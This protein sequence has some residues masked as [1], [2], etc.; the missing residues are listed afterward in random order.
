MTLADTI[1]TPEGFVQSLHSMAPKLFAKAV[2]SFTDADRRKLSKTAQE[3]AK[4]LRK[5][6]REAT[7]LG[8]LPMAEMIRRAQGRLD[9]R[10]VALA[11]AHLGLLTVAPKSANLVSL[12]SSLSPS[13]IWTVTEPTE[14]EQAA[15]Q[16]KQLLAVEADPAKHTE[17]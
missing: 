9:R 5:E 7:T 10:N 2:A 8:G 6:D 16:A 11:A 4:A 14:H 13:E 1:R 12:P 15:A 3:H 17:S